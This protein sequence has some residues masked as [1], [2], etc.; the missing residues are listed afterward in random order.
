MSNKTPK[1]VVAM[2][3]ENKVRMVDL[4][5][6][7]FPGVWQHFTVP[8]SQFS[9]SSFEDGYGFDGSSIRGWQPINASDMLVIPD[10]TT[11]VLDP[12]C[13]VPTLSLICNITDPITKQPY[14]RNPRHVAMKAEAFVKS[15]GAGDTIRRGHRRS[16]HPDQFRA[17]PQGR[18]APV[19]R[20][21]L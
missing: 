17:R 8:V 7:D 21:L 20:R 6:I 16:L 19:R 18:A 1:E 9:E 4:K 10:A 11:A 3:K 15:S 12:F 14:S 2:A 13:Q 5:F